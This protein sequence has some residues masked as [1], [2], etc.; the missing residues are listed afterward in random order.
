MVFQV[1]DGVGADGV[2]GKKFPIFAVNRSRL[3]L[4]SRRMREKQ[5]KTKNKEKR[6]KMKNKRKSEENAKGKVGNFHRP[7]LHQPH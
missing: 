6:R 4:S 7:Q 2:G 5:R 3:P 1:D